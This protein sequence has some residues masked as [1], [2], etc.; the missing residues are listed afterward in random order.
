MFAVLT[1]IYPPSESPAFRR[2]RPQSAAVLLTLLTLCSAVP[3]LASEAVDA[4]AG[5]ASVRI[6]TSGWI[7]DAPTKVA[8]ARG[9]F[10]RGRHQVTLDIQESGLASLQQLLNGDAEFALV[11]GALSLHQRRTLADQTAQTRGSG[12]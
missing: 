5:S 11:A 10:A 9:E 3:A 4:P 8:M 12:A 6:A 2:R 7:A 1:G